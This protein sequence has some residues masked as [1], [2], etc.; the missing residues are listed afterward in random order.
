MSHQVN[1]IA[2][3]T[4]GNP[5]GFKQT[6]FN[7]GADRGLAKSIKTFDLKTDAIRLFPHSR[8]YAIRKEMVNGSCLVSYSVYSFAKEQGSERGG[9]FIGSSL[10]FSDKVAG[11]AITVNCL[12]EF[13]DYL[14]KKNV[15]QDI[16]QVTHSDH[17]Q[18]RNPKDFTKIDFNLKEVGDLN[19]IAASD[20]YL[21]V[22]CEI[23]PN[24][25]K[26]YFRRTQEL[27][28]L[29]D[30]IYFTSSQEIAKFV[31][32]RGLFTLI[33]DVAG[34]RDL[35]KELE[36]LNEEK[37]R[38]M[39]AFIL[40]L[41]AEQQK[42]ERDQTGLKERYKNWI[43][44]NERQHEE[45]R[46]RIEEAKKQSTHSGEVYKSYLEKI[47]ESVNRLKAR[48]KPHLVRRW[49]NEHKRNFINQLNQ[50]QMPQA[51]KS[52]SIST[53]TTTVKAR[54]TS[55]TGELECFE[56]GRSDKRTDPAEFNVYKVVTIALIF[57]LLSG[58]AFACFFMTFDF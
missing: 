21:V 40:E 46:K 54:M 12:N 38:L 6:F 45:N 36:K 1:I 3:G 48:E 23:N 34:K 35:D 16:I 14:E 47:V 44:E 30:T 53:N 22:F 26:D 52:V 56:T 19:L 50:H 20:R 18:V 28:N 25:L 4:F 17:F 24:S 51:L 49:L 11:E 15:Q 13:H 33:Q 31:N 10:L 55:G 58:V 41:E 57:L 2:F 42:I 7:A 37:L 27:L 29:Y 43:A 9:T 5:N 32:E 8:L 39:Q